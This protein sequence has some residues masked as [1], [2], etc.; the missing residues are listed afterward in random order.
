MLDLFIKGTANYIVLLLNGYL[1]I[2]RALG[3]GNVLI[4]EL[5][6]CAASPHIFLLKTDYYF[7]NSSDE[8]DDPH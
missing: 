1:R 7:Y 6:A 3:M 4:I 2:R 5:C 8:K